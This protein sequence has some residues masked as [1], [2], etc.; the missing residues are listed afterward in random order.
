MQKQYKPV[1]IYCILTAASFVKDCIKKE[2]LLLKAKR[3]VCGIDM[4]QTLIL[5][6]KWT[7]SVN[8]IICGQWA[9][10]LPSVFWSS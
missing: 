1:R 9:F 10:L 8:I 4:S 6:P 3:P 2:R 5:V 7:T